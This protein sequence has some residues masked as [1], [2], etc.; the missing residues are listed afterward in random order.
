MNNQLLDKIP[1]GSVIGDRTVESMALVALIDGKTIR[2]PHWDSGHKIWLDDDDTGVIMTNGCG[3]YDNPMQ[4]GRGPW[5]GSVIDLLATDWE[6]VET[7]ED[8]EPE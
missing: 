8:A 2:R 4:L 5:H 6:V 1:P 7:W 3:A